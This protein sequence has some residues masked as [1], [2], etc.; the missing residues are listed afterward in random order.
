[1]GVTAKKEGPDHRSKRESRQELAMPHTRL[2][3]V[4]EAVGA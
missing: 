2:V 4:S 1:M 3:E